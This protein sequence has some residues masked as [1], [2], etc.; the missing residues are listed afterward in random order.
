[1]I[2]HERHQDLVWARMR[3]VIERNNEKLWKPRSMDNFLWIL[4]DSKVGM[5][6]ELPQD[7]LGRRKTITGV[8]RG[9]QVD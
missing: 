2:V 9:D 7:I 5:H 4:L 3:V 6:R 8:L 1:M